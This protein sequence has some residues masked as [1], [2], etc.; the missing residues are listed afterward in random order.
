M[1]K[2][3][4][5]FALK[6]PIAVDA[7]TAI[8]DYLDPGKETD[9]E[10]RSWGAAHSAYSTCISLALQRFQKEPLEI[11]CRNDCLRTILNGTVRQWLSE[12]P[13]APRAVRKK[14]CMAHLASLKPQ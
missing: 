4:R 3:N 13:E 2:Q 9:T 10:L 1:R 7:K 12:H 5:Y 14:L 6:L 8:F 11:R